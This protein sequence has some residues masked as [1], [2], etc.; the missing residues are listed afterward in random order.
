M[1]NTF[2]AAKGTIFAHVTPGAKGSSMSG[3]EDAVTETVAQVRALGVSTLSEPD[4]FAIVNTVRKPWEPMSTYL[5][6]R[7]YHAV[8]RAGV[9]IPDTYGRG[10]VSARVF[11]ACAR[12]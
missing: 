7:V 3:V 8:T 2:A 10:T 9:T 5:W 4:L 11:A 12:Y 6:E 1:D